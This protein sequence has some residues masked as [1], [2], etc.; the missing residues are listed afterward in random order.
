MLYAHGKKINSSLAQVMA[1][2]NITDDSFY[3]PSR[4]KKIDDVLKRAQLMLDAG[5]SILDIGGESTRQ[6]NG[7]GC[8]QAVTPEQEMD[9]VLPMIE[10]LR[11]NTD[12]CLSVDTQSTQVMKE[13]VKLGVDMI[14][15]VNA[16]QAEAAM[17]VLAKSNVAACF[18]HRKPRE[19]MR[20]PYVDVLKEVKRFLHSCLHRCVEH[21]I[22]LNRIVLD[23][24]FGFDKDLSDNLHLLAH[25]SAFNDLGCPLLIGVSRKSMFEVSLGLPIED[26]LPPS[27]STAVYAYGQGVRFFRVHD[28]KETVDALGFIQC[29]DD[30][31]KRHL[32]R[33]QIS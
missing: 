14:N 26:R 10:A 23:P 31:K 15:D 6:Y 12:A 3:A 27:L 29:I 21:G 2:I 1:V 18:M 22:D 4:V 17:D 8:Y 11:K 9:R 25:L 5:A 28:V 7:K 13:A 30:A 16:F 32:E 19:K 33:E 24:G 20:L